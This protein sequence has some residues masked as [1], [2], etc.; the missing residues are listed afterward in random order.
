MTATSIH[1]ERLF[2]GTNYRE[3]GVINIEN[4]LITGFDQQT[5]KD[6]K[7]IKGLIV[8]GFVDIQ[9]N[10]GGGVLF[11]SQPTV[12]GLQT[13]MAA[14]AKYGTTAML[15]T[16]ITDTVEVMSQ[17][18]DAVAQA[19]AN[20][21]AGIIGIHFEGPHLSVA[22]KGAHSASQI[23][24]ISDDEW[25]VLARKDIG[26]V[27][28]TIAPETITSADIKRMKNMGIIICIGHSNASFKQ[29]QTAINAGAT[30]FTH[31]YNAMSP[32]QGR[33]PGVTGSAFYHDKTA[34]GLIV[35]G[36]H[37]DYISCQLALKIKPKGKILLVT[38]AMPPVGTDDE[39]FAFFDRSVYL[40]DGKLTSTTG[41]LAGSV[42]T[43]IQAVK[44][45]VTKLNQPL[46][47]AIR[48]ASNYPADFIDAQ[49][50]GAL[51]VGKRAD[52]VVLDPEQNVQS[53]WIA[54]TK[55]FSA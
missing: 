12:A 31:L 52:F 36:H 14:H 49:L 25:Q 6:V 9:V 13:M 8:P 11:N 39:E 43:M 28:V 5:N 7:A 45:T 15:P 47:E 1:F 32:L 35:D 44:N 18:A 41:E 3:N 26:I 23:R 51:V 30:G 4:G 48:M 10:G 34:C 17:A 50:H 38:D 21:Q 40:N 54:G 42:L 53:T 19:I 29:S 20:G 55:I 33:E 24:A 46:D 27:M 37:V 2:D 16:I 22:K